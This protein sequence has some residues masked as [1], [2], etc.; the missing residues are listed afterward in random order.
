[1]QSQVVGQGHHFLEVSSE[2]TASDFGELKLTFHSLQWRAVSIISLLQEF[3]ILIMLL[4]VT[5]LTISH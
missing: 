1:L 2:L 3:L 5:M 4:L